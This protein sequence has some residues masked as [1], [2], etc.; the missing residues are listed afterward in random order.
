MIDRL[1]TEFGAIDKFSPIANQVSVSARRAADSLRHLHNAQ[2][3]SH[4][5][6][7]GAGISPLAVISQINPVSIA[8]TGLTAVLLSSITALTVY[9]GVLFAVGNRAVGAASEMQALQATLVA[10]TGSTEVAAEKMAFLRRFALESVFE[11]RD[12]ARAGTLLESFGLRMERILPI[13]ARLG[14]VFGASSELLDQLASAFG[15]IGAGQFGEA[16]EILRRFGIGAQALREAGIEIS[17]GGE[18]KASAEQLL[19]AVESIVLARFGNITE[20]MSAT[21]VV[22]LSNLQDAIFQSLETIGRAILPGIQRFVSAISSAINQ[23]REL[24]FVDRIAE[25]FGRASESMISALIQHLP[26]AVAWLQVLLETGPKLFVAIWQTAEQFV[27]R[28]LS[29]IESMFNGILSALTAFTNNIANLFNALRRYIPL[30]RLL[31]AMQA[32]QFER[33]TLGDVF[34]MTP[35]GNLIQSM[36]RQVDSVENRMLRSLA[37]GQPAPVPVGAEAGG[38]WSRQQ[39]L[40][41][42]IAENTRQTKELMKRQVDFQRAVLGGGELAS[43]GITPVERA[44]I[45]RA[46]VSRGAESFIEEIVRRLMRLRVTR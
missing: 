15:R 32:V 41:E 26:R 45:S 39:T 11:F 24:G 16:M 30:L 37:G 8:L 28:V 19:K 36:G 27:V 14:A 29:A 1:L 38:F 35:L 46:E 43:F 20:A 42:E 10:V 3:R 6:V 13:I 7:G 22:Q 4:S 18:I 17:K 40:T 21:L 33:I 12:L 44:S 9:A 25:S 23:L 2:V 5:S 31:P 34:A